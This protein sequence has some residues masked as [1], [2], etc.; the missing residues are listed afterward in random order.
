[1]SNEADKREFTRSAVGVP[2]EVTSASGDVIEATGSDIGMNGLH[3]CCPKPLAVGTECTT[4][5]VLQEGEAQ[6][7][8]KAEGK[9]VR[10]D[11]SG[12][13]IKFTGLDVD[14]V[15]DL[16]NLLLYNSPDADRTELEFEQHVGLKK[17]PT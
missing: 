17:R 9:V 1:M 5:L 12:M 11:D 16:H 15:E 2:V 4:T 7:R 6:M 3:V 14:S 8:V 10:A 13:G